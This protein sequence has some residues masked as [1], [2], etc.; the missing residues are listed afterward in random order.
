MRRISLRNIVS[1]AAIASLLFSSVPLYAQDTVNDVSVNDE[2]VAG[3]REKMKKMR[4]DMVKELGLTP[5][6][7]EEFMKYREE[8]FGKKKELMTSMRNIREELKVELEKYA[9]DDAR[10]EALVLELKS[11]QSQLI[12]SRVT[13]IKNLKSIL[14][15]EQYEKFKEKTRSHFGKEG[16]GRSHKKGKGRFGQDK[17]CSIKNEACPV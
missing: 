15:Q 4:G 8:N 10:I 12:D 2:A 14:T 11:L 16:K 9:Q 7:Q 17:D 6:Q 3:K 13:G 1:T 5:E